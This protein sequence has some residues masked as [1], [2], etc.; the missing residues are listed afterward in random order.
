[1][2]DTT[3]LEEHIKELKMANITAVQLTKMGKIQDEIEGFITHIENKQNITPEASQA[4]CNN[5][6]RRR[7][8]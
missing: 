2:I 7:I 8:F 5:H 1:M 6:H 3:I 4:V